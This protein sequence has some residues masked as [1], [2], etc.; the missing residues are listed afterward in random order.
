MNLLQLR[1]RI[2]QIITKN[3]GWAEC[4]RIGVVQN[5]DKETGWV[6]MEWCVGIKPIC[7]DGQGMVAFQLELED[8]KYFYGEI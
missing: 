8:D 7:C 2:D 6:D 4:D 1:D 5:V 3:P